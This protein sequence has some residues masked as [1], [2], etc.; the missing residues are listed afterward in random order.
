M[1]L[2]TRA[3][4]DQFLRDMTQEWI[5]KQSAAHARKTGRIAKQ[6]IADGLDANA[7]LTQ[8]EQMNPVKEGNVTPESYVSL[9]RQNECLFKHYPVFHVRFNDQPRGPKNS[10]LFPLPHPV[11]T[12][13]IPPEYTVTMEPLTPFPNVGDTFETVFPELDFHNRSPSTKNRIS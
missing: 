9:F 10:W 4:Q 13:G 3:Q 2:E 7:A 5:S 12:V 1:R 6:L 11:G 8:A